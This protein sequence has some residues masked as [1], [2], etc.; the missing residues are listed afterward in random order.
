M[1]SN[2]AGVVWR[3]LSF[4]IPSGFPS[5]NTLFFL[6]SAAAVTLEGNSFCQL[7]AV[8]SELELMMNVKLQ[9]G[10]GKSRNKAPQ[11]LKGSAY[12]GFIFRVFIENVEFLESRDY[13]HRMPSP[14]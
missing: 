8:T 7:A 3:A 11:L 2:V 5:L 1:C 9:V 6:P 14:L 4:A 13:C 12:S 10:K